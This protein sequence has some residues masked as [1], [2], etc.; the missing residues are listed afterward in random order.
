MTAVVVTSSVI[1]TAL[2]AFGLGRF[3]RSRQRLKELRAALANLGAQGE[4]FGSCDAGGVSSA[5][6]PPARRVYRM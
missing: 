5:C 6:P 4:S 1:A 3:A 2:G